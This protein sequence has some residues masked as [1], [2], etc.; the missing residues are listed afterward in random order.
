MV[1]QSSWIPASDYEAFLNGLFDECEN[2]RVS[3]SAQAGAWNV[4]PDYRAA[5]SV[6]ATQTYGTNRVN[7]VELF[8]LALNQVEPTVYDPDPDD[9]K[10]R[11]VNFPA[12]IAAREK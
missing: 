12:T 2:N 6:A 1:D 9:A 3:F 11:R 10:K 7:A 5:G 8:E 4:D